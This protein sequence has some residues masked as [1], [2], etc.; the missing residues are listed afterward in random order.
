MLWEKEA[1]KY[2]AD[3]ERVQVWD[4]LSEFYLDSYRTK[5]DVERIAQILARSPFS[6]DELRHIELFEVDSVCWI[7]LQPLVGGEWGGFSPDWLIPKCL[8]QSRKNP[9]R[10]EQSRSLRGRLWR[11]LVLSNIPI[12]RI[13]QI[14]SE[15]LAQPT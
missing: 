14:R 9:Y 12:Q 4:A 10:P 7:N 1:E 6:I 15:E 5:E 11:W 13:E 8:E 2:G 3:V